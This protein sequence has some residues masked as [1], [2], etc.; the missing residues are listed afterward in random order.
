MSK[1]VKL[2]FDERSLVSID[3]LSEQGAIMAPFPKHTE[4]PWH[5]WTGHEDDSR[6]RCRWCVTGQSV[7]ASAVAQA[8]M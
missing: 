2:E 8:S 5:V 4:G 3:Q 1:R 7:D 6:T